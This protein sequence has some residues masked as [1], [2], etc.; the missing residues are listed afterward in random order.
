LLLEYA[1]TTMPRF[2]SSPDTTDAF[3]LSIFSTVVTAVAGIGGII[4]FAVRLLHEH[5]CTCMYVYV[6]VCLFHVSCLGCPAFLSS[7]LT[8]SSLIL[9]YGL[10]NLVDFLSSMV[11]MWR[12]YCPGGHVKNP[13]REALL[14]KREKR[15]SV[16]ISFI[17]VLLG[18]AVLI[19]ALEDFAH[20]EESI[21]NLRRV[22][23]ISIVSVF[24]FGAMTVVKF[25]MAKLLQSASLRKDG[26]CSL[27]GTILSGSLFVNTLIIMKQSNAW[28]LD[29]FVAFS[30]AIGSLIYGLSS[31]YRAY[32]VQGIP[33]CNFRWWLMSQGD[34]LDEV[35]GRDIVDDDLRMEPSVDSVSKDD[36]KAEEGGGNGEEEERSE[37]VADEP[38][39]EIV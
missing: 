1:P 2:W 27:I 4:G 35:N 18:L 9:C 3:R 5:L 16:A 13:T 24:V 25:H 37:D 11:V 39:Q 36:E 30:C 15:A 28:W 22:A 10:E 26:V 21:D 12:F 20:G 33:V 14:M 38:E 19:A 6:S 29:P 17:L 31:I 32:V 7:Q 8:G 34:G 23:V